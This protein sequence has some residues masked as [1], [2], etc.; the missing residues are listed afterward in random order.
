VIAFSFCLKKVIINKKSIKTNHTYIPYDITFRFNCNNM[1]QGR[2]FITYI[3]TVIK[4]EKSAERK[5][6][7]ERVTKLEI[8]TI[9]ITNFLYNKY[10]V[11]IKLNI[12]S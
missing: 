10:L 5:S 6:Q 9:Q 12:I 2:V 4:D 3:C 8:F 11:C 1:L 7:R